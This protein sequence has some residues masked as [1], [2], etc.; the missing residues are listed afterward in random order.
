M[1]FKN[2]AELMGSLI[3]IITNENNWEEIFY[4]YFDSD[5]ENVILWLKYNLGKIAETGK[6]I[7]EDENNSRMILSIE[8]DGDVVNWELSPEPE[9][10]QKGAILLVG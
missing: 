9:P 7:L 1:L 3:F 6:A 4:K 8:K 5:Y 10:T 2:K